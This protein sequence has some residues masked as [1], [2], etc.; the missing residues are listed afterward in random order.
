MR[1]T[2]KLIAAPRGS[3]QETLAYFERLR[4][5]KRWTDFVDYAEAVFSL[6]PR[7]GL[8]PSIVIAQAAH[9]TA[10]FTSYWWNERLNP[11]GL[12][13]TGN[14]RQNAESRI[15][16]NGIESARAQMAHLLLY[17]SG[18]VS[19]P[20]MPSDDPRYDAYRQAYGEKAK[21]ET[22]ADLSRSWATDPNYSKGIVRHGNTIFPNLPESSRAQEDEIKVLRGASRLVVAGVTWDG[23]QDASLNGITLHADRRTVTVG[24]DTLNIR[25]YANTN[26]SISPILRTAKYGTKIPVIGWVVGETVNGENR[27]WIG[28]DHTRIW[29]GGTVEK[30][31]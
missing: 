5:V 25:V 21:A 15:F 12:G 3:L 11:A 20:M 23:R 14:P 31:R 10:N 27:W 2:D 17:A 24:V 29:V 19:F 28:A 26:N 7:A 1:E 30:P 8:D 9:E 22:I 16:R 18:K 4:V 6:G 13:I